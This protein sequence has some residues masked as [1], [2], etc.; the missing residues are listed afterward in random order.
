MK[1]RGLQEA[2][3]L[4]TLLDTSDFGAWEAAVG[5]TLGHHRSRLLPGSPPF[6]ARIRAGAVEEFPVLLLQ[7]SGQLELLREQCDHGVLWLPLQGLSH[8]RINGE[9][10]VAEPGMGLLFRPGDQ[11]QGLTSEAMQGVSIL[12]PEPCLP[13]RAGQGGTRPGPLLQRGPAE[14]RLIAAAW[15]LVESAAQPGAGAPFA[16]EALVDALQQW[17]EPLEPMASGE[18]FSA[19]RRRQTVNEA[20]QWMEQHLGERFSIRQLGAALAVSVRSLQYSFQEELGCTPMAQAKRQ[21]L[22]RLRLLLQDPDLALCS[23]AELMGAAGLLACG[24]TAADY[25]QW[26]GESPR[27][28][29]QVLLN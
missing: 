3:G 21:R 22:R 24:A 18:R 12:L 23:I 27:R 6:E 2:P 14:R 13:P 11:L 16:A 29:R 17:G 10:H 20:C 5:Q 19:S 26:C 25:R 1:P 7:G 4:R 15:R 9:E 28:T 8:E